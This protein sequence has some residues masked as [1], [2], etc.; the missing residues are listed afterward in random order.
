[1]PK[2]GSQKKRAVQERATAAS[3]AARSA[4]KAKLGDENVTV[5]SDFSSSASD[6]VMG[7]SRRKLEYMAPA[8]RQIDNQERQNWCLMHVGQLDRFIGD[9]LCPECHH[10]SLSVSIVTE[11]KMGFS[12]KLT[13]ECSMINCSFKNT[14][15]SSYRINDSDKEN[16]SFEINSKMVLLSHELG[17]SYTTVKKNSA[18]LRIPPMALNCFQNHDNRISGM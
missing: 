8:N 12:T 2:K 10:S 4:Q 3:L 18:V 17:G 15:M 7:A 1:M 14:E 11:E 5:S 13:L 6:R 16:V 9:V